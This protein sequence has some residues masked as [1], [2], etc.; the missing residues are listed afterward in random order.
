[1]RIPIPSFRVQIMALVLFFVINS[2]LFYRNYF[3]DSFASY[4]QG[5]TGLKM[6]NQIGRLYQ[7]YSGDLPD[8]IR[9]AYR[10]DVEAILSTEHQ[11][12][13][14]RDMFKKE[15]SVYS[16]FIF[17]F[18]SIA[19]LILFLISIN[20]ITRP[21]QRLQA[22]TLDLAK[23]D[24]S[25]QVTESK[26]SPLNDMIISFNSMIRE[27]ESSRKKLVQAEKESAWRDMARVLAHEIKNPLTP[28]RLSLQRLE[29]KYAEKSADID[30]VFQ[31]MSTVMHEEISGLEALASEFS[32]FARLPKANLEYFHLTD[33]L[34]DILV[35]YQN[36]VD[37][38][39]N[40]SQNPPRFYGDI[41]QIKQMLVN[42][43]QNAIQSG[44]R[45]LKIS[46]AVGDHWEISIED[47]GHGIPDEYME[48]IFEPY[49]TRREKG[50]GIGLAIVKRIIE[51][52]DGTIAVKS[53]V[54]KGTTFTLTFPVTY[55][56]TP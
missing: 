42:L 46:C 9:A 16:G 53:T 25:I 24:W 19:V 51:N 13:I 28:M 49:F 18:L 14:L 31:R 40:K 7:D 55:E 4:T 11:S 27:L 47:D 6:D 52:H 41:A 17:A 12:S 15:L 48:K 45:N 30:E 56:T 29:R 23:G 10:K 54:G 26:L 8:S 43:I 33:Q 21:L 5:V 22:A 2:A 38:S 32:Q 39:F 3:L 20:L 50:T 35:P 1:M 34:D 37:I 44:A 36:Q